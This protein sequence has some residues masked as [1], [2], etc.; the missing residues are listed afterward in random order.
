[1]LRR[2]RRTSRWRH[3]QGCTSFPLRKLQKLRYIF[4][5]ASKS[6]ES[7]EE[8]MQNTNKAW[9]RDA[10]VYR[11][12]DVPRRVKC[13]RMVEPVY[14]VFC[15]DGKDQRM[16]HTIDEKHMQV[17]KERRGKLGLGIAQGQ[18]KL[19][20]C[21]SIIAESM[22][23][24]VG[25]VCD[26][27]QNAVLQQVFTWRSACWWK[28]AKALNLLVGSQQP[29]K[30]DAHMWMAKSRKRSLPSGRGLQIQWQEEEQDG[31]AGLLDFA[32]MNVKQSVMHLPKI[33][34]CIKKKKPDQWTVRDG[35]STE[36]K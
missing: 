11:S 36:I 21:S 10:R 19:P 28:N 22:W 12:K 13:K 34:D 23:R 29:H 6:Q 17:Q 30:M 35:K 5:P 4:N 14:S 15:F 1:M 9:W 26:Q 7:L 33:G 31:H 16:G 20:F 8:L 3:K 2:S 18:M 25:W 32:L 27:T 24:A